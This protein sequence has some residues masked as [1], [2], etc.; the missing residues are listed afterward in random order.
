V[1]TLV[2]VNRTIHG[3]LDATYLDF[4]EALFA[5]DLES[6]RAHLGRF[7]D[8]LY[9]H[10]EIEESAVLPRF[11][12]LGPV[13][14]DPNA[15]AKIEGDHLILRRTLSAVVETVASLDA[16]DERR[17]RALAARIDV[18]SR[19]KGILEHHSTREERDLYPRLDALLDEQD[20]AV[21]RAALET[22][23]ASTL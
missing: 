17:G 22:Q 20:R 2:D 4:L 5:A 12:A 7:V 3:V 19:L 15:L 9:A 21:V 14:D 18:L 10:M 11:A 16:H 1:S 13:D 23:R 8:E 6:A